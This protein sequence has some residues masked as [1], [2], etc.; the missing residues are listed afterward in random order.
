MPDE[1]MVALIAED[2]AA[3]LECGCPVSEDCPALAAYQQAMGMLVSLR[4]NL[5]REEPGPSLIAMAQIREDEALGAGRALGRL[6]LA[7]RKAI[8]EAEAW[9]GWISPATV[10]ALKQARE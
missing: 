1:E 10:A 7:A 5:L 4:E 2:L 3:W 9:E 8:E 6:R